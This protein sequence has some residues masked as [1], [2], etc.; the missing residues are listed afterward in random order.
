MISKSDEMSLPML[1][2]SLHG[3]Q[4]DE[5][6]FDAS[7]ASTHESC[8]NNAKDDA[9]RACISADCSM[10]L[11]QITADIPNTY[12][13]PVLHALIYPVQPMPAVEFLF[14]ADYSDFKS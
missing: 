3:Q 14:I 2:A 10:Q 11:L 9:S 7:V 8:A 12:D 1:T 13:V 6:Q 5:N 4:E